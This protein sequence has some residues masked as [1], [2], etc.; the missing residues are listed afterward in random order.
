MTE[1]VFAK[2]QQQAWPHR[3][4]GTLHVTNIAGGVPNNPKV[5]AGWIKTKLDSKDDLL[6]QQVAEIMVER[7]VTADEAVDELADKIN[8]NGFKRDEH[9]LYVEGRQLKAAIKEAAAEAVCSGKLE[10]KGWGKTRKNLT[11]FIAGHVFVAED[12]LHLGVAEPSGIT[13]AFVHTWRGSSIK[14]EEYVEDAKIDF[15]VDSD[16][17]FSDEMWGVLWLTGEQEGLGASRSQ[18]FGRYTVTR[19]D[20]AE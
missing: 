19:W 10:M 1:S 20:K 9:G 4:H 8:I 6:R 14:Y 5:M 15:T 12:R 13:Q 18:G 17:D 16:W 11:N 2:Y 7:G 3:F